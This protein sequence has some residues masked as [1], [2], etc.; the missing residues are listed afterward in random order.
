MVT[1]RTT[2]CADDGID[3]WRRDCQAR[4]VWRELPTP[5]APTT[6]LAAGLTETS[7]DNHTCFRST[8]WCGT[9]VQLAGRCATVAP[10][11]M[12]RRIGRRNALHDQ[13]LTAAILRAA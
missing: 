2:W 8:G 3:A 1:A 5:C 10:R 4:K 9:R 13:Y 6:G 12:G 7:P 11:G